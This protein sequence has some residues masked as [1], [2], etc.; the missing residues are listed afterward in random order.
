MLTPD[1]DRYHG[2]REELKRLQTADVRDMPAIDRVVAAL[3]EEYRRQKSA[4]GQ[5]G[6]NPIEWR[7]GEPPP[8]ELDTAVPA[9][10]G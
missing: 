7:H 9:V 8:L 5:H 4:D 2:L 1:T 6:N 3:A 10:A